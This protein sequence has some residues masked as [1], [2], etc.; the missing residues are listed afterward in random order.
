MIKN[1]KSKTC[2]TL[3]NH[4]LKM[5]FKQGSSLYISCHKS[6]DIREKNQFV[7]YTDIPGGWQ[8]NTRDHTIF[9]PITLCLQSKCKYRN[10]GVY[11]MLL[12]PFSGSGYN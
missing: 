2:Q 9:D 5:Y 3:L 6:Y 8:T 7:L 1:I 12:K 11:L 4:M 10:T